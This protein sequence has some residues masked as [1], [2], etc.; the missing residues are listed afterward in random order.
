[1][2]PSGT[3][4]LSKGIVKEREMAASVSSVYIHVVDS[5]MKT[6]RPEFQ[7][8][9][10]DDSVLN[11]VQALWE[12]KMMQN[13]AIQGPI[14]HA[15]NSALRGA[16]TPITP[17]H[18]LNV[19]Y[20]P[21]EE[22]ETPTAEMLF[23]PTPIQTPM[24]TP[25]PGTTEPVMYQYF[26]PG[27]GEALV[28][29]ESGID[30]EAKIGRPASYMQ[31]PA[32]WMSHKPLGVDVNVAY[33]EER[34]DMAAG[35]SQGPVTKDFFTLNSGKRKR[36]DHPS[37]YLPGGYIPQQDGAGDFSRELVQSQEVEFANQRLAQNYSTDGSMFE[38]RLKSDPLITALVKAKYRSL[39]IPQVDG[40]NDN[41]DSTVADDGNI[42]AKD[43]EQHALNDV[44][45]SKV[46]E[47]EEPLND[48]DD[49]PDDLDQ[50]SE[51]PKTDDLVL[52]QFEKVS[53]TKNRWKCILKDG[54]MHLNNK[55]ILF[56][57]ATG[58]FE[59]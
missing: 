43:Q 2:T 52:A 45:S 21:T 10:L 7:N 31:Q 54:V 39:E 27:P 17:V 33:E 44:A 32:N 40:V 36:E 24:Q 28:I 15:S 38:K 50:T 49:D 51:D 12:L 5:V 41:L 16:N 47:D 58:E 56:S 55:D 14:D 22:Y 26:P 13:G 4:A 11:E 9:G 42:E 8:E 18:D 20:E 30:P 46:S 59:F 57:K 6:L 34:D 35:I 23:P 25:L 37:N 48:N 29:P 1:M 19:P 3:V 53:R